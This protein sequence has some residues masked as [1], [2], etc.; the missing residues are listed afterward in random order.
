MGGPAFGLYG[1]YGWGNLGDAAIQEAMLANLRARHPDARFVGISLNPANTT[2]IHGIEAVPILRSW[3][4]PRPAAPAGGDATPAPPPATAHWKESPLFR[5]LRAVLR[6]LRDALAGLRFFARNVEFLGGLDR[7]VIS[8]GGQITDD[9]GGPFDHPWS[10]FQWVLAARLAGTPVSVVSVGAGPIHA[11]WS[12]HLFFAALRLAAERSVRDDESLEFLRSEGCLLP[13]SVSAD[14]ALSLPVAVREE[15]ADYLAVVGL[16]PMSYLHPQAGVW[17]VHDA[18]GYRRHLDRLEKVARSAL[19]AGHRVVLFC[20]QIRSDRYAFD[21]LVERLGPHPRLTAEPTRDLQH[22]LAQIASVD[23]VVTSRLHG[24]ILSFLQAVPVIALSYDDKIDAVMRQFDQMEF[25]L[26]ID[27]T[28][29]AR[30]QER[31]NTLIAGCDRIRPRLAATAR[32]RRELLEAQYDRLF[33]PG[34]R[35]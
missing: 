2:A 16:S 25:C 18:E 35:R 11:E 27:R 21:E 33:G 1:P 20:N 28:D 17:P 34:G 4:P 26:D 13:V 29:D 24:V 15:P 6:P 9:W 22:L 7:L 31:L 30:L 32:A 14:L 3:R 10:M 5:L 19:D 8:G 12:R 23:V